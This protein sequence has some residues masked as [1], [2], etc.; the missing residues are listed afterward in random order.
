M[1]DKTT[2]LSPPWQ[3]YM[4]ELEAMFG[5][6]PDISIR[7]DENGMIIKLF[8]NNQAK[9]DA[10]DKILRKEQA[11]GNVKLKIEVVPPNADD[12]D[13]L[14]TFN[15][16]F[17]GNP[18]LKYTVPI[19]C[20]L[21]IFR[22]AVFQNKVV[23]FFNDQLDDLN[24]NKSMLFQEIARDIFADGLDVNYCTDTKDDKLAKPLGEWP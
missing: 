7:F 17:L 16:A 21:G 8:V 6:D 9:C 22:Y 2:K 12:I 23:Q 20:P 18:A 14:D 11:F 24:G 1:A 19:E 5:E 10:L 15:A 13:I 4:H 3:T